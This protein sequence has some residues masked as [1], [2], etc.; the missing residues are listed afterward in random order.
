MASSYVFHT[1]DLP[2]LDL[3]TNRGMDFLAPTVASLLLLVGS[4]E[5]Q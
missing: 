5:E 4:S 1:S 3:D 2:K